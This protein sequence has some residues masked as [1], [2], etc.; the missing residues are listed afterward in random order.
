MLP[1]PAFQQQISD[2]GSTFIMPLFFAEGTDTDTLKVNMTLLSE[3][4][5]IRSRRCSTR[6]NLALG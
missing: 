3:Q 6:V 4:T 2:D 1:L 5:M